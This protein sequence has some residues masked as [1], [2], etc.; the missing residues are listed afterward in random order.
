MAFGNVYLVDDMTVHNFRI[1]FERIVFLCVLFFALKVVV[2]SVI[3]FFNTVRFR[4]WNTWGVDDFLAEISS[5]GILDS[6]ISFV[7]IIIV[8]QVVMWIA[9]GFTGTPFK[10][11]FNPLTYIHRR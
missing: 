11:K 2:P 10:P 8:S 1:G 6:L 5:R 4:L 3:I 9:Y 7:G